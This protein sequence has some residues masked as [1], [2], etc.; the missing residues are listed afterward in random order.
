MSKS[1]SHICKSK[2]LNTCS[3]TQLQNASPEKHPSNVVQHL[4]GAWR[5]LTN[6]FNFQKTFKPVYVLVNGKLRLFWREEAP[7]EYTGANYRR[8][9]SLVFPL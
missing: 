4:F 8:G 2:H 1:T 3:Q 7:C 9:R 6:N 5:R